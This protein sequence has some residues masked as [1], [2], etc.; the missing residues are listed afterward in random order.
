M[1]SK[2]LRFN[3]IPS[4][5]H[6]LGGPQQQSLMELQ[7][8]LQHMQNLLDKARKREA[9]VEATSMAATQP[10]PACLASPSQHNNQLHYPQ[11]V[12]AE[13]SSIAKKIVDTTTQIK[14]IKASHKSLQCHWARFN[15][16]FKKEAKK[17][18]A[19][20]SAS[21][22]KEV[23]KDL[24][25]AQHQLIEDAEKFASAQPPHKGMFADSFSP[26]SRS[27]H[28]SNFLSTSIYLPPSPQSPLGLPPLSSP[29]QYQ[30]EGHASGKRAIATELCDLGYSMAVVH[31]PLP[32]LLPSNR[33]M[34]RAVLAPSKVV[35]RGLSPDPM[36]ASDWDARAWSS[37][38]PL[39]LQDPLILGN[40]CAFLGHS[41]GSSRGTCWYEVKPFEGGREIE[42]LCVTTLKRKNSSGALASPVLTSQTGVELDKAGAIQADGSSLGMTLPELGDEEGFAGVISGPKPSTAE[43]L[44]PLSSES[45]EDLSAISLL[46]ELPVP[47]PEQAEG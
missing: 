47:D 7:A 45:L 10:N 6:N 28:I 34:Q 27:R 14:D 17:V 31:P 44:P 43:E 15:N 35:K 11:D 26:G 46:L 20:M 29:H 40:Y 9:T 23:C 25:V 30:A 3:P 1:P 18:A 4:A 36:A 16:N 5:L 8:T 32:S 42:A 38:V 41:S 2:T 13:L 21:H 22:C 24:K 33:A 39:T 19:K 12:W 37:T